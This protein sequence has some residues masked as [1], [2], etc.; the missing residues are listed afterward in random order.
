[1]TNVAVVKPAEIAPVIQRSV[2]SIYATPPSEASKG[3]HADAP[4]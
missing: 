2:V 4:E 3:A 1:V